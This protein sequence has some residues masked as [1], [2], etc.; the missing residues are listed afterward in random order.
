[1]CPTI[2]L[3][4]NLKYQLSYTASLTESQ[5]LCLNILM[6]SQTDLHGRL[7]IYIPQ[8]IIGLSIKG[9]DNIEKKDDVK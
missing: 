7:D 1:M 4:H 8:A 5:N 6:E 2:T 3:G 9:E